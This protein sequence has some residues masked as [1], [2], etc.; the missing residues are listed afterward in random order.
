MRT[1]LQENILEHMDDSDDIM[2][3]PNGNVKEIHMTK[4]YE[5]IRMAGL[6]AWRRE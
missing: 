1:I 5:K 4:A 2:V 3:T 6:Q